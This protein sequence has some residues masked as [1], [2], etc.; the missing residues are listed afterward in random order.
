MSIPL[1]FHCNLTNVGLVLLFV[2][3]HSQS[4]TRLTELVLKANRKDINT[5]R[6][7]SKDDLAVVEPE[8]EEEDEDEYRSAERRV[9]NGCLRMWTPRGCG[10]LLIR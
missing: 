3:C 2:L 5:M 8:E 6:P 9:G 7:P 4:F 10:R 1:T